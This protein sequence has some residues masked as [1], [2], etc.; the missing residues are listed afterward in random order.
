V[1]SRENAGFRTRRREVAAWLSYY[2][3]EPGKCHE[4]PP[5]KTRAT[6]S[7]CKRT[8]R[9]DLD[10]IQ[11]MSESKCSPQRDEE[12]QLV[13]RFNL[14]F[15]RCHGGVGEGSPC[16]RDAGV[17]H[18]TSP[19]RTVLTHV[20]S[21]GL[22]DHNAPLTRG[23]KTK[24]MYNS[25]GNPYLKRR[26]SPTRSLSHIVLQPLGGLFARRPWLSLCGPAS[27]FCVQSGSTSD[28]VGRMLSLK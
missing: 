7:D 21:G 18:L 27:F 20:V 6:N 4:M 24:S 16:R 26:S 22:A 12:S 13:I 25:E 1:V 5:R 11:Q 8:K 2:D 17:V 23:K 10:F 9:C 14:L 28:L 19:V 3:V 15:P